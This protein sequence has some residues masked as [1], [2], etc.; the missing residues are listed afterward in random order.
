M[1]TKTNQITWG[2][3]HSF[4]VL[5]CLVSIGILVSSCN[6]QARGF[7]LPEGD[8]EKGKMTYE[9]LSCF[10]CH[11]IKDIEWRGGIDSL[12]VPLGGETSIEKSYGDLVTSIINPSHKIAR[13][14]KANATTKDGQSKMANY[15]EIMTVQELVD[16]VTYLQSEYNVKSPPSNYYPYHY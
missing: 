14:Y 11:S 6:E 4:I 15:N 8:I 9:M 13:H 16:I 5:I 2:K 3:L 1:A 7:A 10:E 12:H